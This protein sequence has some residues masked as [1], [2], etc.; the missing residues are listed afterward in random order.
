MR[1]VGPVHL[2]HVDE[3]GSVPFVFLVAECRLN[4]QTTAPMATTAARIPKAIQPHCVVLDSSLLLEAAAAAAAAAAAGFTP[5][6][7]VA[8]VVVVAAGV[9]TVTA[10]AIDVSVT[11]DGVVWVI[12]TVFAGACAV[13]VGG[14]FAEV[15]GVDG[16]DVERVGVLR[17]AEVRVP[18]AELLPPPHDVRA[19]AARS[20]RIPATTSLEVTASAVIG[21]RFLLPPRVR[22]SRR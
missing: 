11:V 16:V 7:V 6:V 9:L 19:I 21:R 10:G 13:W 3:G 17:V 12:V 5:E 20:P 15:I 14:G 8:T 4:N 1:V 2:F 22:A 18:A